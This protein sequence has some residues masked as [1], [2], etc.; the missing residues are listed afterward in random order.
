MNHV[1]VDI[2]TEIGFHYHKRE[3]VNDEKLKE[4]AGLPEEKRYDGMPHL[5]TVIWEGATGELI[6]ESYRVNEAA[7]PMF[8]RKPKKDLMNV[9]SRFPHGGDGSIPYISLAWA[10]TWLLHTARAYRRKS[11]SGEWISDESFNEKRILKN[12]VISH[13]PK[14]G[15]DWIKGPIS[16]KMQEESKTEENE[17][18]GEDEIGTSHPHGTKYKPGM[19]R[20]QSKGQSRETGVEY[21]T[22]VIEAIGVEHKETTRNFDILAA[23]FT[24][25]LKYLHDDFGII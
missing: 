3:E 6:E 4:D 17:G 22:T 12:I 20:Y 2:P 24:D 9:K 8:K 10:H 19:L 18:N 13:R 21:T 25:V 5:K 23:V 14:G 16:K 7:S 1:G 11:S 15:S